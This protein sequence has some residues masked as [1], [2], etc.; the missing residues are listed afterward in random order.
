MPFQTDKGTTVY[1]PCSR[2]EDTIYDLFTCLKEN[3]SDD[4]E[5]SYSKMLE[6]YLLNRTAWELEGTE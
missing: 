4:G 6:I 2:D 3:Q 1:E 5:N